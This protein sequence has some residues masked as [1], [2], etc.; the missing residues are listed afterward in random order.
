MKK[1]FEILVVND[2]N[3]GLHYTKIKE[4]TEEEAK[5]ELQKFMEDRNYMGSYYEKISEFKGLFHY[6][7]NDFNI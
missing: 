5:V 7:D 3:I 2:L 1:Q 4:D 6:N